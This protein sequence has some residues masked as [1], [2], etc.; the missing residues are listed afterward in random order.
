VA[1]PRPL[2]EDRTFSLHHASDGGLVVTTAGLR[3]AED[4]LELTPGGR[5]PR[6]V[7]DRCRHLAGHAVLRLPDDLPRRVV[8]RLLRGELAVEGADRDGAPW[9]TGLQ[10]PGVLDDLYGEAAAA[11]RLGVSWTA[12]VP[13]VRLWAPTARS[14]ILHRSAAPGIERL[15]MSYDDA[16]GVWRVTGD[17]GWDR[18]TYLFEVEV[19]APTTG[20]VERNLLTDPYSHALTTDSARSRM[21]DL[22]DADLAPAGWDRLA[23]PARRGPLSVYELHVRDFSASDPSVP[24]EDVGRFR[25]F[26]HPETHGVAHLRSLAAAGLTHL[27]LLPTNDIA[28]IPEDPRARV[29]PR[30]ERP[31]DPASEEPQRIQQR[32]RARDAYNWGYDPYH[33]T[34]PEGSYASDPEGVARIREFRELVA[35]V[36]GLG[37][38]VVVDVVY[39]H[40]HA[41]GQHPCSVLDRIVPG[42]YHRLDAAG[43]VTTST[44]CPNTAT[45]HRMMRKLMVDSV[46]D[47]VR[48]YRVDGFRFDLMGHH[49]KDDLLAVR[50]ALD[51]LTPD[52]DGVAGVEVLLYGEGWSFGEVADDRRFEQASQANMAGTAIGTFNDR[53]RD[54]VRGGSPFGGLQAQGFATGLGTDPAAAD[55]RSLEEQVELAN[56]AN[57]RV[58]VGLAG[59]LA[60]LPVEEPTG[61]VVTGSVHG[62]YAATPRDNV[63]YVSKHDNETLHDAIALKAPAHVPVAER[64]R[65]QLLALSTVAFAQGVAF[66]HAGSD[67]L[68]SKSLDRNSYD[69][70]DHFNRLDWTRKHNNFGVGLPPAGENREAWEVHRRVLRERQAPTPAQIDEAATRFREL[71]AIRASSPLF[72]LTEPAAV[73]ERVRFLATGRAARPGLIV[74]RLLGT[75]HDLLLVFN[76]APATVTV[77]AEP[78]HGALRLHPVLRASV[79]VRVRTARA[80]DG[81]VRVPGRT[82]AVF[83]DRPAGA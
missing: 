75:D 61:E 49:R 46:V 8:A 71:L 59:N 24:A 57:L 60:H 45:E 31:D 62:G 13:T 67:L 72:D 70:G 55:G 23:K 64:L 51:E 78:R 38:R 17:A 32:T 48:H 18:A 66:F 53:L 37:L 76:A 54:A 9:A 34:V 39:N 7:V 20:R 10:V 26:T 28:T 65:M 58:M 41:A 56:Q 82:T 27:H 63:V 21:V 50:A 12:G 52:R 11:V 43:E 81:W 69:S 16:T 35:A 47:W 6:S 83:V 3:G 36:N 14:V 77:A 73:R 33:Y 1:V 29:V 19:F 5:L 25:A 80:E 30:I 42:Y 68:R 79:D 44:C 15:P 22:D 4:V 2:D 74:V 40:T